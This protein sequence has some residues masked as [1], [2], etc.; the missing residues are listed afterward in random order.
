MSSR[1]LRISMNQLNSPNLGIGRWKDDHHSYFFL[2]LSSFSGGNHLYKNGLMRHTAKTVSVQPVC[3]RS[4][5]PVFTQV[6]PSTVTMTAWSTATITA[7]AAASTARY[8]CLSVPLMNSSWNWS[9]KGAHQD[10]GGYV[11]EWQ[12]WV[13]TWC[14]RGGHWV[15]NNYSLCM[16]TNYDIYLGFG[17]I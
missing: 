3:D 4:A 17:T 16:K 1:N 2:T 15:N 5:L 14:T 8:L 6:T 7:Q 10:T 9:K 12:D 13:M 11:I